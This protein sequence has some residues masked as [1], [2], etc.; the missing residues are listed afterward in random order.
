MPQVPLNHWK[1]EEA[2]ERELQAARLFNIDSLLELC[3]FITVARPGFGAGGVTPETTGLPP[4]WPERLAAQ[5][6]SRSWGR[7]STFLRC[8]P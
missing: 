2:E 7:A 4:P 1:A 3:T 6:S 5:V 8:P